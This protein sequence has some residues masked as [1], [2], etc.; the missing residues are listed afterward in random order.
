MRKE[1]IDKLN[2]YDIKYKEI[3]STNSNCEYIVE[4]VMEEIGNEQ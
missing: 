1:I 2:Q 3:A 4:E